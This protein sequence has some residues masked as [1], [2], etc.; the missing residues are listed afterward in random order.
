MRMN[1][2]NR[3]RWL[4]L[5]TAMMALL[6]LPLRSADARLPYYTISTD[7][8]GWSIPTPHSYTPYRTIQGLKNP[9]DIL[10]TP[11]D[12]I[13]VADTGNDRVVQMNPDGTVVR[14]IPDEADANDKQAKLRRP[15]GVFV[16]DNGDIYVA[17]TGGMRIVVYDKDGKFLHEYRSPKSDLLPANY[18]FKPAKLV[19]DQRGY[20]YIANKGGYQG[21]LQLSPDGQFT[22]FFGANKV[23]SSFLEKLKRKYYTE[24]QLAEE[25]KLL[26]G[27][28]TN[29]T[30][31][32]NGFIYTVNQ[33]L[34]SGQLKRLN[35]AGSDLFDDKNFAPWIGPK[36]RFSFLAVDVDEDE[37]MTVVEAAS[38]RIYQYDASGQLLFRFGN[39]I[40]TSPRAGLFKRP[41]GVAVNST[42]DIFVTDSEQNMI[43]VFRMTDFG[44]LV[45]QSVTLYKDGKYE[46]GEK[47]WR[48][49]LEKQGTFDR[50]YQGIAKAEYRRGDYKAAAAHFE[51]AY[52]KSGYSDAFWEIRMQWLT[53]Y[54]G[55]IVTAVA[56]LWILSAIALGIR[57]RLRRGRAQ[58]ARDDE[59][60]VRV[61]KPLHPVLYNIRMLFVVLRHPVNGMYDIVHSGQSRLP[62]AL[63]FLLL[64][65]GVDIAGK[66]V[67]S[68]LFTDTAFENRNLPNEAMIYFL[69]WLMWVAANYLVGSVMK[70]EGTLK[71]VLIV[72]A[73]AMAPYVLFQFPLQLFS[74]ALTLQESILYNAGSTA[75]QLWVLVLF[76]I[77]SQTAHN[78]N[79]K[80][81]LS[82]NTV[83]ILMLL[84]IG[85]FAFVMVGLVYQGY[86]FFVQIGRELMERA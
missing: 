27:S 75:I 32:A 85:I 3:I 48:Q 77:A 74:N 71:K 25:E 79:L 65:F 83:S 7:A 17:D 33:N 28:I 36:Q 62:F 46:E 84:C 19:V 24:E 39:D 14:I 45:H 76:F 51:L 80:E 81:V 50:A 4:L 41:T 26:P 6:S 78:Y 12:Q 63:A 20:L 53:D 37:I 9:E 44:Q 13:Y 60:A 1:G 59:A 10:I 58:T 72:N 11:D 29:M 70:G 35:S 2:K 52:D 30:I 64:G 38:G 61:P 23:T 57:K 42:G 67:V 5:L 82:M 18:I 54:F 68:F 16:G 47:V 73:Y 55:I 40:S 8:S 86:D 69:P 22:G 49:V 31:D 34:K 56:G 66:F 43:Q 21:L 15:E